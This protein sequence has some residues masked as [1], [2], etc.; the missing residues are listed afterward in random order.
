MFA[1][2]ELQ[3]E[4]A[5]LKDALQKAEVRGDMYLEQLLVRVQMRPVLSDIEQRKG[6]WLNGSAALQC[7]S[8]SASDRTTCPRPWPDASMP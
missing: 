2:V 5:R 6:H 3:E 7:A 8:N 1:V 4:I